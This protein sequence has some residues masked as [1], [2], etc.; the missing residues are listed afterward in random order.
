MLIPKHVHIRDRKWLAEVRKRPCVIMGL[1]SPKVE[2]AH[3]RWRGHGGVALKPDDD[4][5]LPL[6]MGLHALQHRM[7]EVEFWRTHIGRNPLFRSECWRLLQR[8]TPA[9][10]IAEAHADEL[11][12]M[13]IVA[14]AREQYRLWKHVGDMP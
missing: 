12:M 5:A 9:N 10:I 2:A 6:D 14:Y 8:D 7:G 3:V 13:A 4:R 11:L 1:A